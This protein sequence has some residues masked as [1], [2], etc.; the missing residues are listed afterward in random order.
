[1]AFGTLK[2]DSI[3]TSTKTVTVDN[4]TEN[5]LPLA[6][7]TVSGNLIVSGN[8][9]VDGTTTTVNSTT[10]SVDDKNIEIGSVATP[11]DTTAD[12][13]GLTLKG[14]SDKT[15]TWV[16]STDCWTFN[17]SLDLTAGSASTPAL[18]LNGDVNTGLFQPAADQ[19]AIATA[20]TERFKV[21]ANG[22][23]HFNN[24][25][26]IEKANVTAGKLSD[27]TNIDLADGM[28]HL[29]TTAETTT[30]TPNIR[31]DSSTSLNSVMANGESIAVTIITTAAAAGYSAQ[32]TID[33]A[34]VTENWVGGSAPSAGGTSGVDIYNYTIIKTASATFTVIANYSATS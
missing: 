27:N 13:G 22:G 2:V 12:G 25:E 4:L 16:N 21:T 14:A 11:S 6:G 34:A 7:G 3:T 18:I 29:F 23:I 26:L 10:L 1:M 31:V 24:A 30:S 33:G 8:L 15:L 19:I 5:A 17:Q 20:G 28:V 9:T 32:L